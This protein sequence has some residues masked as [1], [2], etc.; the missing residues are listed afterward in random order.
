MLPT[1]DR[2]LLLKSDGRRH[3]RDG[4]D[5]RDAGLV[6]Q[7]AS[8]G[9]DGLEVTALGLREQGSEGQGGLSRAGDAGEHHQSVAG[10][11]QVDVLEVVLARAEHQHVGLN[12]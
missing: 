3:A 2:A 6:D 4:V 12:G 8:V 9:S 10:D 1:E 11:R 7:A 5:V